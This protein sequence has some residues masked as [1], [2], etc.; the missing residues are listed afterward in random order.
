MLVALAGRDGTAFEPMSDGGFAALEVNLDRAGRGAWLVRRVDLAAL[1]A[2]Q[3]T[4]GRNDQGFRH[5]KGRPDSK[6]PYVVLRLWIRS[7]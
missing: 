6:G 4:E 2:L 1:V 5:M 3:V 7:T